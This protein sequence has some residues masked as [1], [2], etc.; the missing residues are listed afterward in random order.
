MLSKWIL[1]EISTVGSLH[2][3]ELSLASLIATTVLTPLHSKTLE[4]SVAQLNTEHCDIVVGESFIPECQLWLI[5]CYAS[6][7]T[8]NGTGGTRGDGE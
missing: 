5:R 1:S 6:E 3:C 8:C 2:K 7:T 4:D